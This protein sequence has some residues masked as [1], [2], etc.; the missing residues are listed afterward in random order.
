MLLSQLTQPKS[1][2]SLSLA[3]LGP[4][5]IPTP[6]IVASCLRR[7]CWLKPG[8]HTCHGAG[9]SQPSQT[10]WAE[11][12][13]G[14][15]SNREEKEVNS[16]WE[17]QQPPQQGLNPSCLFLV[18]W[19]VGMGLPPLVLPQSY[20]PS[21]S[22]P[23]WAGGENAYVQCSKFREESYHRVLALNRIRRLRTR[24]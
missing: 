5:P 19:D 6:V 12:E 16:G 14:S 13:G 23:Q 20:L 4:V 17:K 9:A 7:A 10:T 21:L 15:L 11:S 2:V 18:T 22:H 8:P 24:A 1:W 3:V